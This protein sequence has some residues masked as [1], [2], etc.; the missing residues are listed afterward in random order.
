MFVNEQ[1][2]VNL[3]I[4]QKQHD[5]YARNVGLI[6]YYKESLE[7]Q[8]GEKTLGYIYKQQLVERN[9]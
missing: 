9:F 6:E 8:P 2:N 7:T 5:I 3:L 4:S 1:D